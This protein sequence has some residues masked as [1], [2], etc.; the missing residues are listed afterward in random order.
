MKRS[1]WLITY[2]LAIAQPLLEFRRMQHWLPSC[3]LIEQTILSAEC[4]SPCYTLKTTCFRV[5]IYATHGW[6]T[7]Y[8]EVIPSICALTGC[9]QG[10]A[11]R[12]FSLVFIRLLPGSKWRTQT[13][14]SHLSLLSI[15]ATTLGTISCD[16][17]RLSELRALLTHTTA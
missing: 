8:K 7:T 16:L 1:T 4:F 14:Q 2:R 10:S 17:S 5:E 11:Q 9:T 6:I 3:T 13:T 12:S 15:H